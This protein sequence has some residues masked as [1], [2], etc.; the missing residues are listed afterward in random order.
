MTVRRQG[1]ATF[2]SDKAMLVAATRSIL[3]ANPIYKNTKENADGSFIT[4]VK[5]NFY[6]AST[7][8]AISFEE[9][10]ANTTIRV[11]TTSPAFIIGDRWGY[12]NR[13][14]QDFLSE[15]KRVVQ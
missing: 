15:L 9:V 8:M 12:Y 4:S 3:A 13:Y 10:G 2:A 5:P 7:P 11:S 14:I 1:E 6:L